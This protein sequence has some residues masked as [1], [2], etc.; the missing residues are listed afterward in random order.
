MY[1][2]TGKNIRGIAIL[3]QELD[4]S[5]LISPVSLPG[6][7]LYGSKLKNI[8]I[9][10]GVYIHAA[11]KWPQNCASRQIL[12]QT[13]RRNAQFSLQATIA[14]IHSHCQLD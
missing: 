8:N 1:K 11:L 2:I 3:N 12:C 13:T 5:I 7:R 14:Q 4:T 9:V 10:K 6:V